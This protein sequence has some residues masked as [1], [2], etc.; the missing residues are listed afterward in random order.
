MNDKLDCCKLINNIKLL[1]NGV[2]KALDIINVDAG[3]GD[4]YIDDDDE[5]VNELHRNLNNKDNL[6]SIINK[7]N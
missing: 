6:N 4:D 7:I 1:K 3:D 5:E 2:D